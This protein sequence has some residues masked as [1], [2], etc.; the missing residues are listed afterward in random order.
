MFVYIWSQFYPEYQ[1]RMRRMAHHVSGVG[2]DNYV[3]ELVSRMTL[4][5]G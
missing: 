5:E 4:V 2:N 3:A 1:E